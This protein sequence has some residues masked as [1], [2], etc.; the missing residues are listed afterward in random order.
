MLDLK[1]RKTADSNSDPTNTQRISI[2][3]DDKM[4]FTADQA[5]PR[6]AAIDTATNKVKTWIPLAGT[7]Y[8]TPARPITSGCWWRFRKV[9]QVAVV[10][11]AT[12]KVVRSIDV[13]KAPQE[14]LIS[15]DDQTAYVSCN[16]SGKVAAI[17]LEDWSVKN[18][19]DAGKLADGLAWAGTE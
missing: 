12:L 3:P 18:L 7:G 11:L 19:I 1:A 16:A 17:S 5:T 8:G 10:D 6:L 2:T 9:G 4:V 13:P 14:I 15:P